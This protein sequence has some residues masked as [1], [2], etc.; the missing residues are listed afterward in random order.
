MFSEEKT[1]DRIEITGEFK[2]IHIRYINT[3][4]KDGV[5]VSKSYERLS[6]EPNVSFE[7]LPDDAKDLAKLLWTNEIVLKYSESFNN[8]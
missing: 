7:D 4:L 2:Y 6:F 3:I 8:P 5:P 1:L